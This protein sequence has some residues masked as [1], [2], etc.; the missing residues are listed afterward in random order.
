MK[1]EYKIEKSSVID[2]LQDLDE[3]E[4]KILKFMSKYPRYNYSVSINN[5]GNTWTGEV[6]ITKD[7]K[8]T[9]T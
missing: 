3:F 5:D 7:E 1:K 4:T 2:L 6:K 8:N 9:I